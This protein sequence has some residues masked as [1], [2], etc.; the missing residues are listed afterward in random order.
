MAVA[1]VAADVVRSLLINLISLQ[2]RPIIL[3]LSDTVCL[4]ESQFYVLAG[5]AEGEAVFADVARAGE[6][7]DDTLAITN[8]CMTYTRNQLSDARKRLP[9]NRYRKP[10]LFLDVGVLLV[11]GVNHQLATGG[12]R[13]SSL[14]VAF[15]LL[16]VHYGI[17]KKGM[18]RKEFL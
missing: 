9:D 11:L 5:A 3:L 17:P 1:V 10:F 15:L 4:R 18:V 2:Q 12:L 14:C 8:A 6:V 7:V 13:L 16:V